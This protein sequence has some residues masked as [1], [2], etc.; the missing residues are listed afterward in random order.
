MADQAEMNVA[1][2]K[3]PGPSLRVALTVLAVGVLVAIPPTAII[4]V[5]AVRTID[6]S[7]MSTPG[8]SDRH[9]SPGTWFVFQ[10]TGTTAGFGGF[11]VSHTDAPTLHSTDV[12]VTGPDGSDVPV[13]YVT[14]NETITR[15]SSIYTAVVQFKALSSG[16]Y[17]IQVET[18]DSQVIVGRSL[19]ET[20]RGVVGFAAVGA[21][22]GLLIA[23]GLVLLIVGSVRRDRRSRPQPVMAGFFSP[24]PGWYPD[25][26]QVGRARWWDGTRWTDHVV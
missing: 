4:V 16:H 19:G 26:S 2:A 18:A 10:R 14:V 22:G 23:T 7:P 20:I 24:P 15:G 8:V 13:R 6:S 25:P 17:T 11:T 9:L 5:R 12:T 3:K 21:G 1:V